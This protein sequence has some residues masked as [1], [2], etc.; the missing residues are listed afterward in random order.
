MQ[1][2]GSDKEYTMS[3]NI[4]GVKAIK[5]NGVNGDLKNESSKENDFIAEAKLSK[6]CSE[7]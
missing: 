5:L 6:S 4:S 2:L 7:I 3:E 1:L